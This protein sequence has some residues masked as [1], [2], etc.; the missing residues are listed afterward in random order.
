MRDF[1][2]D[3]FIIFTILCFSCAAII[4]GILLGNAAVF[5]LNKIPPAWLT[6]YGESPEKELLEQLQSGEQRLKSYPYK[7]LFSLFFCVCA[8]WLVFY[9]I[10][11]ALPAL[12][13]LW[14]L[15]EISISDLK[16]MIVPDQFVVLL[17]ICAIGF[18]RM[19]GGFA[20]P[21]IGA[22]IGGGILLLISLSGKIFT[23]KMI[24][25][26]GDI[27]LS[28]VLGLLTGNTGI[29]FILVTSS[30]LS[31]ILYSL[32]ILA[33]KTKRGDYEPYAHIIAICAGIY[34][35][36]GFKFA[37]YPFFRLF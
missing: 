23:K 18:V 22:L 29:L 34:I 27:K 37:S 5:V 31:G 11:F 17:A 4:V 20:A 12:L 14:A 36:F 13:S 10:Y 6:E 28:A 30:I 2:L 19:H 35:L 32:K 33:G 26:A 9:D 8:L 7:P 15:L 21:V 1:L 3:N 24:I 16:Y 25:G